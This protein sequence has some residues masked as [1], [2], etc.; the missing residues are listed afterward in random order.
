MSKFWNCTRRAAF[1]TLSMCVSVRVI[2]LQLYRL[3]R[4]FTSPLL[5]H[6]F[7]S[8]LSTDVLLKIPTTKASS[9]TVTLSTDLPRLKPFPV[10]SFIPSYFPHSLNALTFPG[11]SDV[12]GNWSPCEVVCKFTPCHQ[13]D[14][15]YQQYVTTLS[16]WLLLSLCSCQIGCASVANYIQHIQTITH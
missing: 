16:L 11:F 1:V 7:H 3:P 2:N 4:N 8:L 14:R 10:L 12:S 9:E 6:Q 13:S 5:V 15:L